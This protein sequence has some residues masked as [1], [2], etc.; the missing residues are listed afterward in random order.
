MTKIELPYLHVYKDRH[1]HQRSYYRRGKLKQAIKGVF[2]SPEWLASYRSIHATFDRQTAPGAPIGTVKNMVEQYYA[3]SKFLQ[4]DEDTKKGYRRYIDSLCAKINH[5]QAQAMDEDVILQWQK[6]RLDKPSSANSGLRAIKT[7]L[8]FAVKKKILKENP[9]AHVDPLK[10]K[11]TGGWK[12]WPDA[13]LERFG[14]ESL[15]ASRTAFYLALHTGQRHGDVL[16][17]RWSDI[18]DGLIFVKQEK[19]DEELWIPI[20]PLL[21]AELAATPKRGLAIVQRQDGKPYTRSGFGSIWA[22]EQ[23]RLSIKLPFH[24]LRKNATVN[25]FEVGCTP[26]QVGAITGHK[27]LAMLQLYG[28]GANQ[29]RMALEAM[30]KLTEDMS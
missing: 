23:E 24:G 6:K 11:K 28:K 4:L 29:K 27:T 14:K 10:I 16:A 22:R 26:Q 21:A 18:K 9:A 20:H 3:S 30:K 1:G 15:G 2:R 12:A 5:L 19:T 7:M 17:M 8:N 25:L 13:A